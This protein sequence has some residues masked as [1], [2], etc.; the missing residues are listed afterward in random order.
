MSHERKKRVRQQDG[1][2]IALS[3]G[4][5][6]CSDC[7][8]LTEVESLSDIHVEVWEEGSHGWTGPCICARCKLSIPIYIDAD[9]ATDRVD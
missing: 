7:M 9:D 1:L 3:D 5:F 6:V 4:G 2:F 8:T